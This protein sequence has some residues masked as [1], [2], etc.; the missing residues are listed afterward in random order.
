M[1]NT[2]PVWS[3]TD[4]YESIDSQQ[5]RTDLKKWSDEAVA[6]Q[7]AYEGKIALLTA[8][9]LGNLITRFEQII[10]AMGKI[11]SHADLTFAADTSNPDYAQHAQN[12]SEAINSVQS[13]LVFV[14]LELASMP[15]EQYLGVLKDQS[16][17]YYQPWLRL[18][19]SAARYNLE[20][21][22]EKLLVEQSPTN[23]Q[24]WIRLFDETFSELRFDFNGEKLTE[25]E[26]LN[27]LSKANPDI[28][29]RAAASLSEVLSDNLR[30]FTLIT[31]TISKQKDIEE[32]W[33]GYKGVISSRNLAND[34]DDHVV[35]TLVDTVTKRM[36][37]LSHRYYQMKARWLGGDTMA[38]WDRNAPVS[39]REGR[40]FS[41]QEACE[42]VQSSFDSFDPEMGQLAKQ[43]FENP[44]IDSEIR[45]GKASGAFSHP[46]VTTIHPYILMNFEGYSRDVMTLAHEMG[47]GVHQ[48]L[49]A[50]Q[51][52]LMSSTPLT[53]AETASVFSEMLTFNAILNAEKSEQA[54]RFMLADKIEDMLNTVVR[55]VAFH[56]FE[57]LVHTHRQDGELSSEQ[58]SQFWVE[59]QKQA[60]GPSIRIDD[61]F[62]P[63]WAYVPHFVHSP[64][65][66][67]AY[68]FG[69][70]LVNAL[71]QVYQD[72]SD[73]EFNT[74]YKTLLRSGGTVRFD[75]A[76]APFSLNPSA[77]EFWNKGLDMISS[78]IDQ[79]EDLQ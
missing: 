37:E 31:N 49:A 21:R 62:K 2:L 17:A 66:V 11:S 67:Y 25:T 74:H 41:W 63:I 5:I 30:L 3:L 53:L 43:F 15:E 51:G 55:Q 12:M 34:V 19:R 33:R 28:R 20:P 27:K 36:P 69:D 48:F 61:S 24:A 26:I 45:D 29:A 44:W 59:T 71:W 72:G 64:F 76:L 1:A 57:N 7:H 18:V 50:E 77:P 47:H 39:G 23:R 32:R 42:I 40:K 75:S 35:D 56:N 79:V 9:E 78:M 14:E 65:Y 54:K 8:D 16:V 10:S 60:L 38:W 6:L 73:P 52:E 4:L 46:T 58:I 13:N 70:C 68:A 22:L